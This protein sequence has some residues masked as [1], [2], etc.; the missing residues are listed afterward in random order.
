MTASRSPG[1]PA[2]FAGRSRQSTIKRHPA[3][4]DYERVLT[5]NPL[6]ESLVKLRTIIGQNAVSHSDACISQLDNSSAGVARIYVSRANHYV[7]DSRLGY[8]F[9]AR[10]SAPCRGARLQSNVKRGASR[11]TRTEI[12]KALNLSVIATRLPMMPFRHYS[13]ADYQNRSHS[14]IGAR[15]AARLFGLVQ[16]SVH[17]LFVAFRRHCFER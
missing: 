6:I 1:D 2:S 8:R 12:A 4:C 5:N 13:I 15:P 9:R 11:H 7:F 14:W 17:E 10:S 16:R 3:F